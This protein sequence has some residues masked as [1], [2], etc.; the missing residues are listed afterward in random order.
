MFR[1]FALFTLSPSL[2]IRNEICLEILLLRWKF[3]FE[4]FIQIYTKLCLLP[5]N[6][7]VRFDSFVWMLWICLC[8]WVACVQRAHDVE[9]SF[10]ISWVHCVC[11]RIH[12]FHYTY[13]VSLFS[14][15]ILSFSTFF[16]YTIFT[17]SFVVACASQHKQF[18]IWS[19]PCEKIIS[20]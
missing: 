9:R 11:T 6:V 13:S 4:C 10:S 15:R 19:F 8:V 18:L 2:L 7:Y 20:I 5:T 16:L 1:S 3:C 17:L 14:F 12:T